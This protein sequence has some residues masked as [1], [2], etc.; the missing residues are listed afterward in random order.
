MHQT[1][2]F[3]PEEVA[4]VP[5]FGWGL[6]LAV[7]AA[8]SLAL[9]GWS[10]WRRGLRSGETGQY[11]VLLG[12]LGLVIWQVMPRIMIPGRGLPIRSY[13]VMLLL[14]ILAGTGLSVWRG[15]RRG[16]DS[17]AVATLCFWG[18]VC[19]IVGAR[20]FYVIEYWP[21]FQR[22]TLAET[23][24]AIFN[25][26]QGGIVVYGALLGGLVG[27]GGYA[28]KRRMPLLAT[29]D[30]L[31]P[32]MLLGLAIGRV[33]CFLNGCCF[34]GVCDLPWAVRFPAG[35]PPYLH[36]LEQGELFLQGLQIAGDADAAPVITAVE[37]GSPAAQTG[38]AA[39]QRITHINGEAVNTAAEARRRL[40][41]LSAA[42]SA[43][44]RFTVTVQVQGRAEP[45]RWPAQPLADRSLPVHPTQLYSSIDALL[46]CGFLLA[47][48]RF[49]RRD[50]ELLAVLLTIH[51]I[52]RFL[53]EQIRTDEPK[54]WITHLSIGQV[55]SVLILCAAGGLWVYLYRFQ[56]RSGH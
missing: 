12:L 22:P 40:A 25:I 29:F 28:W 20:A 47:Y 21:D 37:P 9:L 11:V 43:T 33:G 51:P 32:G 50:G 56:R 4:G 16:W 10:V 3:I 5:V 30:L 19:G 42:G 13:G 26:T 46:L 17:E 31:A 34:G 7:W 53:M 27:F 23:F 55:F 35:S 8:V 36:Q 14:A 24:G 38:V 49:R 41:A 18:V 39:G 6:L 1:L 54:I 2:F 44:L 15:R 45:A 52:S 48:D